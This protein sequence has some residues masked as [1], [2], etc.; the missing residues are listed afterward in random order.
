MK[1]LILA[2]DHGIAPDRHA[3]RVVNRSL[4]GQRTTTGRECRCEAR[5]VVRAPEVGLDPMTGLQDERPARRLPVKCRCEPLTLDGRDVASMGYER[6]DG[7]GRRSAHGLGSASTKTA[8]E[9]LR[10]PRPAAWPWPVIVATSSRS[11]ARSAVS[12]RS[13]VS[14]VSNPR[15]RAATASS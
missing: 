4:P 1:N 12:S 10:A 7:D 11:I 15:R 13:V 9:R 14:A 6:D 3:H 5:R 8:T 2:D